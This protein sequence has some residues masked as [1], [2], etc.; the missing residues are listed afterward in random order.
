MF[1]LRV[2]NEQGTVILDSGDFTYEVI[3]NEVLDWSGNNSTIEITYT[4]TGF[5]P[6][7]CVFCMFLEYPGD[8]NAS[9]GY[10]YPGLPYIYP[11]TGNQITLRSS[12]PGNVSSRSFAD[13]VYR[14]I[15]F[16]ML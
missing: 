2:R 6:N 8:Y 10:G 13:G 14:L 3:F 11:F 16:R 5:D 15:A 1:G 12:T 9:S 7:T 4:I